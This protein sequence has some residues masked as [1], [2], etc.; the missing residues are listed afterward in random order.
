MS[1]WIY[2]F[3]VKGAVVGTYRIF[4]KGFFTDHIYPLPSPAVK[5]DCKPRW[6]VQ[7]FGRAATLYSCRLRT[8]PLCKRIKIFHARATTA[9]RLSIT[10]FCRYLPSCLR[11]RGSASPPSLPMVDPCDPHMTHN[12]PIHDQWPMYDPYDPYMTHS[13]SIYYYDPWLTQPM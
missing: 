12:W 10:V 2:V 6:R 9:S 7:C 8:L 13:W 3:I 5:T 11:V 4:Y 1:V